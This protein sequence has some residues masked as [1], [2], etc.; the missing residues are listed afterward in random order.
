M[1]SKLKRV[2]IYLKGKKNYLKSISKTYTTI[3]SFK[4]S[5]LFYL[6]C[7]FTYNSFIKNFK[8]SAHF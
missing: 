6:F 8:N 1:F 5:D 2:Y 7:A 4:T 3:K